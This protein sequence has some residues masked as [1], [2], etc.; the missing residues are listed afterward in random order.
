MRVM[1]TYPKTQTLFKRDKETFKVTDEIRCPEFSNI[2]NYIITEKIDGRNAKILYHREDS[3]NGPKD[4]IDIRGRTDRSETPELIMKVLIEMF[5]IEKL[6]EIFPYDSVDVILFGEVYGKRVQKKGGNYRK[7]I[8]FRLFDVLVDKWWLKWDDVVDVSNKIGI[9]T[10]P[11]FGI[12]NMD[13][14]VGFVCPMKVLDPV[15]SIVAKEENDK[16]DF[17][18]EG[19]VARSYPMV[20]FRNGNP[21]NWKLKRKDYF[22]SKNTAANGQ[23]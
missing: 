15:Y 8:S 16:D 9:K 12:M 17:P 6:R 2:K 10:V 14:A 11:I 19:I 13:Q 7:D 22:S 5:P 3:G 23:I 1:K 18:M 20:L 21:I 4:I